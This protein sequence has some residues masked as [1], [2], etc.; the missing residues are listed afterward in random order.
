MFKSI[1][2]LY[3]QAHA[4]QI[5]IHKC[6]V[7]IID[8]PKISKDDLIKAV[9]VIIGQFVKS[10][11]SSDQDDLD[12]MEYNIIDSFEH[13]TIDLLNDPQATKRELRVAIYVGIDY[14]IKGEEININSERKVIS[15]KICRGKTE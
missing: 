10:C 13:C 7:D 9:I 2:D 14:W 11:T 15:K 12:I 4:L 3:E 6:T 8:D 1:D 5:S